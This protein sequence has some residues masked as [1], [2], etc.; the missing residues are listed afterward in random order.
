MSVRKIQITQR[1]TLSMIAVGAVGLLLLAYQVYAIVE[2]P[3]LPQTF[4]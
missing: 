1:V 2:M 4:R 3:G